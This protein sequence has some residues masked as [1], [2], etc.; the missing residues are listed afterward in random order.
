M[1]INK[2]KSDSLWD[3]GEEKLLVEVKNP[4]IVSVSRSIGNGLLLSKF[5][6]FD[7]EKKNG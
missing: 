4:E 3:F 2:G 6:E 7:D 1:F 5:W